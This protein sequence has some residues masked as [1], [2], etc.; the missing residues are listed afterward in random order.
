MLQVR[1]LRVAQL[2]LIRTSCANRHGEPAEIERNRHMVG[3]KR[4]KFIKSQI[5]QLRELAIRNP[6]AI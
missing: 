2:L 5:S 1:Q 3:Y 4:L 6:C